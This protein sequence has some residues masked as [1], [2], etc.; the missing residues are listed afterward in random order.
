V[1][2]RQI[3]DYRLISEAAAAA[4][5]G[6]RLLH[7]R[8]WSRFP[9]LISY[10]LIYASRAAVLSVLDDR[11]KPYLWAYLAASPIISCAAILSVREMF[12]LIFRNYP[13]L[14]T[15]GGWALYAALAVSLTV[16]A[17]S[18]R[19]PWP[20]ES[21]NTRGLF[22]ELTFE[23]SISFSM[24]AIVVVLMVFLS[25]YPLHLERN[26]YVASGFFSA[27]F[28]AQTAV[29]LID[30]ASP[31]LYAGYADD[32]EVV[33]TA[34]CFAGWGIMLRS[35]EAAAP[36]RTQ[37]NKP[38]EAELLQQLDALNSILSRSLRR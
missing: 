7:F 6:A 10:L 11:S 3:P 4:F 25:R 22:Y 2:F 37:A 30:L 8:M 24:A 27:M 33:F 1:L 9:C 16:C 17:I 32:L 26:T 29:K 36:V 19:T 5:A 14:R 31:R 23:R 35:A 21:F 20:G 13:G 38:R 34:L 28:L 12:T 18:L 15:A